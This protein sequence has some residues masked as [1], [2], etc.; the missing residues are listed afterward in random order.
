MV[1]YGVSE[2]RDDYNIYSSQFIQF[3]LLWYFYPVH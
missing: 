3:F 2:E 1:L